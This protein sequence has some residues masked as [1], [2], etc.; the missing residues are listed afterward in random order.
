MTQTFT[1]LLFRMFT[2]VFALSLLNLSSLG[3]ATAND[4]DVILKSMQDEL[5]RSIN[6]LVIQ[7]QE[8]PYFIEYEAI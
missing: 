6:K 2:F 1:I 8:K 4:S 3:Q 5:Q 7:G